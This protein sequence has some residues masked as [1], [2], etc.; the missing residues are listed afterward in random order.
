MIC[1]PIDK[2]SYPYD[3][4]KSCEWRVITIDA[5][6]HPNVINDSKEI[7][8]A[9]SR[10]WVADCL[11][12]W[13]FE[14]KRPESFPDVILSGANRDDEAMTEIPVILSGANRDEGA[15]TEIPVIL[16]GGHRD[17]GAMTGVEGS[18]V[19]AL[20][21]SPGDPSTPQDSAIATS[22][23]AQDDIVSDDIVKDDMTKEGIV[24]G[25]TL[26]VRWLEKYYRT[27]ALVNARILGRWGQLE[28][29]GLI[30]MELIQ[31]HIRSRAG[32]PRTDW[33]VS[34]PWPEGVPKIRTL[35]VDISRGLYGDP[36]VYAS[37]DCYPD[38]PDL[39]RLFETQFD[40]D[41]MA[42]ADRIRTMYQQCCAEGIE[43]IIA[44]DDTGVGG[45]VSDKLKR[46]DIPHFAVNFAQK[47]KGFLRGKLLANARA[48]MYFLLYDELLKGEIQLLDFPVLHREISAIRL[49]VAKTMNGAYKL[50]EKTAT[51]LRLGRSPDYADATVLARYALRLKEIEKRDKLL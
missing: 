1:N 22:C 13:S 28:E 49:D 4:E 37:F 17:E 20:S 15:M 47:P 6:D 27:N 8:G 5:F 33:N 16:S 35:G 11:R 10:E 30:P 12:S 29:A 50:E 23:S 39:Q 48:E 3:A 40:E 26:Y 14:V 24:D 46:D 7:P 31:R 51:K 32:I 41:L 36:T 19:E 34:P 18:L 2:D 45:G 42:T 43:L 44:V 38:A 25:K 9:V 21:H